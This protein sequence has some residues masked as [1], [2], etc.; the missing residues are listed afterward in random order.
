M[1]RYGNNNKES[2]AAKM[3]LLDFVDY[4]RYKVENDLL[5]MEEFEAI[6]KMIAKELPLVGTTD[7]FA[8]F[9][10]RPKTNVSSVIN[11]RMIKKPVRRVFYSFNEF[12][13]IVPDDDVRQQVPDRRVVPQRGH[14]RGRREGDG[15]GREFPA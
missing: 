4:F 5:T 11:R 7:D 10:G 13:K 15:S 12:Q 1:Q 8:R 2:S 6:F 14:G 9:Y 3:L